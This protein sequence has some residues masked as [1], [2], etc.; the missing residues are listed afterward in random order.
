[1]EKQ[2]FKN[3]DIVKMTDW[4]ESIM[5]I[6]DTNRD[7]VNEFDANKRPGHKISRL[8]TIEDVYEAFLKEHNLKKQL[9]A[10]LKEIEKL[11]QMNGIQKQSHWNDEYIS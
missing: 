11:S 8:A 10:K 6:N 2:N 4:H 1:M 9:V 5:K 3:G 7:L